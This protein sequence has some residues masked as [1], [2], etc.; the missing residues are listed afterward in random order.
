MKD[1]IK[2]FYTFHFNNSNILPWLLLYKHISVFEI[3]IL[4]DSFSI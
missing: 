4:K 2:I 3:Y 1:E